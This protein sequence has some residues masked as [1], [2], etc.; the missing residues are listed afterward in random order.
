MKK[1]DN[2]VLR[3]AVLIAVLLLIGFAVYQHLQ[4]QKQETDYSTA[5]KELDNLIESGRMAEAV[6]FAETVDG[7]RLSSFQY[8]QLLK[9]S[10]LLDKESPDHALTLHLSRKAA[11]KYPGRE[12]FQVIYA[13]ELLTHGQAEK[14]FTI[15]SSQ[16][17]TARFMSVT[18]EAA[19]RSDRSLPLETAASAKESDYAWVGLLDA[20]ADPGSDGLSNIGRQWDTPELIADAA[21]LS[22]EEGDLLRA[23]RLIKSI[24]SKDFPE[25]ALQLAYDAGDAPFGISIVQDLIAGGQNTNPFY[26]LYLAQFFYES[27]HNNDAVAVYRRLAVEA[28]DYSVIAYVNAFLLDQARPVEQLEKGLEYF[29][30]SPVLLEQLGDEYFNRGEDEKARA[31]FTRLSA[32]KPGYAR[33]A[34]RLKEIENGSGGKG[35]QSRLWESYQDEDFGTD[36]GLLLAWNLYGQRDVEGLGLLAAQQEKR[37]GP[38]LSAIRGLYF[39]AAAKYEEAVNAFNRAY[40]SDLSKWEYLYNRGL[41][42]LFLGRYEEAVNSFQEVDSRMNLMKISDSRDKSMLWLALAQAQ[43]ALGDEKNGARSLDYALD[44]DSGNLK[45]SLLR[46]S[47]GM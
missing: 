16:I 9:R 28:P 43:L 30:E 41:V 8:L 2:P 38:D 34:L 11:E 42:E 45:A 12:E 36:L 5:L 37:E 17:K 4:K 32:V 33:A 22:A 39:T 1:N 7:S 20:L 15:G 21:I 29:P 44:L 47:L 40:L 18:A 14:A 10:R 19:L 26:S 46:R 25:L 27:G 35:S 31:L 23:S 6:D 24:P 3:T 13:N